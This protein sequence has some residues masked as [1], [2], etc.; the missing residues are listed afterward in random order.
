M[1]RHDPLDRAI[2]ITIA[3]IYAKVVAPRFV[4]IMLLNFMDFLFTR[5][6]RCNSLF[7]YLQIVNFSDLKYPVV[8]VA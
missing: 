2:Y 4:V 3:N 8:I 6:V 1:L 5:D 7:Y